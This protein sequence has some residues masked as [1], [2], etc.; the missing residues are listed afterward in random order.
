MKQETKSLKTKNNSLPLI[1]GSFDVIHKKHKKLFDKVKPNSFNILLVVN[2]PNKGEYIHPLDLRITIIKQFKPSNIYVFDVSKNNISALE[3]I[4]DYLTPIN[5]SKIIVGS[6]FKFGKNLKGNVKLL[7]KY[8]PVDVIEYDDKYQT[9]KIKSLYKN[10][11][12]FEANKLLYWPI[13]IK[14]T[15]VKCKQEGRK[16]GFPTL[17]IFLKDKKQI[18]F[19]E[20]AY[21]SLCILNGI[22][23]YSVTCIF[24]PTAKKGQLIETNIIADYPKGYNGYDKKIKVMLISYLT[25]FVKFKNK[26]DLK[27][28]ISDNVSLTKNF[29][30]I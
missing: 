20:G 13:L 21:T 23:F 22:I 4:Q 25:P 1:I 26:N 3:F 18:Q 12:V 28:Y 2:S 8:F 16:L 27:K 30:E 15:V 24:K 10:G 9:R 14:G 17:N 19:K 11:L 7:Q 29:F 6:D 5:P